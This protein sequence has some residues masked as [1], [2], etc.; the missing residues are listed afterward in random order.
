MRGRLEHISPEPQFAL[1]LAAAA[2]AHLALLSFSWGARGTLPS[3]GSRPLIEFDLSVEPSPAP[4]AA[5]L[6][7]AVAQGA[8]EPAQRLL[9]TGASSSTNVKSGPIATS[10]QG[11]PAGDA[12]PPA[13]DATPPAPS[14]PVRLF[15]RGDELSHIVKPTTRDNGPSAPDL[16]QELHTQDA[17][18]GLSPA[19]PAVAATYHA[20]PKAPREGSAQLRVRVDAQGRVTSVQLIGQADPGQW[21]AMVDDLRARLKSVQ[22]RLPPKST[23]LVLQLRIDRGLVAKDA[24]DRFKVEPGYALGQEP[25]PRGIVRDDSA[26]ASF[27]ESGRISPAARMVDSTW[28]HDTSA[29]RVVLEVMNSQ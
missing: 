29:T 28:F 24:Q 11:A 14:K 26:R 18:R 10:P 25:P 4:A 15:L 20:A 13:T 8:S 16:W 21:T 5:S 17:S 19:S 27:E 9:R 2:A 3:P 12:G 1:M 23:G 6:E 22:F 7:R